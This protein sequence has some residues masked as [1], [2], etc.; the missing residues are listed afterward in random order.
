MHF[1]FVSEDINIDLYVQGTNSTSTREKYKFKLTAPSQQ[2]KETGEFKLHN[3]Y[4]SNVIHSLINKELVAQGKENPIGLYADAAAEQ[5]MAHPKF[6][7]NIGAFDGQKV[8]LSDFQEK[9]SSLSDKKDIKIALFLSS[10]LGDLLRVCRVIEIYHSKLSN[11]FDKV[12]FDVFLDDSE[13]YKYILEQSYYINNICQLPISLKEFFNSYDAYVELNEMLHDFNMQDNIDTPLIDI[14]LQGVNIDSHGIAD[15]EKRN[16]IK[17]SPKAE[18]ELG[19]LVSSLKSCGKRLLLFNPLSSN[20]IRSIPQD[21]VNKIIDEIIEKSDYQII[22]FSKINYDHERFIDL[23]EYTNSTENFLYLL[24]QMDAIITVDTSV[25]HIADAFNIPTYVIFATLTPQ[26]RCRYYPLVGGIN[27]GSDRL[28]GK[29][30]SN[31]AQDL[32][33]LNR[34]Y[35]EN[36]DISL[37]LRKLKALEKEKLNNLQQR[38]NCPICGNPNSTELT[39]RLKEFKYITCS[40]CET[41]YCIN[42]KDTKIELNKSQDSTK[43]YEKVLEYLKLKPN[44]TNLLEIGCKTDYFIQNAKTLGYKAYGLILAPN[45]DLNFNDDNIQQIDS[46][47]YSLPKDYPEK[48]GVIVTLNLEKYTENISSLISCIKQNLENNGIWI[49]V[50]PNKNR[51]YYKLG[52][53]NPNNHKGVDF[54]DSPPDSLLRFTPKGHSNLLKQAGFSL[55]YQGSEGITSEYLDNWLGDPKSIK[56]KHGG[57]NL[58]LNQSQIK[59]NIYEYTAPLLPSLEDS[60]NYIITVAQLTVSAE[61][62]YQNNIKLVTNNLFGM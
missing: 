28:R 8:Q 54:S 43:R 46:L 22:S 35:S 33:E 57:K 31:D 39:D 34:V 4:L 40:N 18:K 42:L 27:I 50:T 47:K 14:F 9:F 13:N 12:S 48:Y 51:L 44:K 19:M 52:N 23:G 36:L 45:T 7:K 55:I 29:F 49:I 24:S 1:F 15:S 41:E 61:K 17:I 56:V 2:E 58:K 32:E 37:I 16:F 59:N 10:A 62:R 30:V 5:I 11:Y 26:S 20:P 38:I 6:P 60:G 53:M 25:Y 3:I 21:F